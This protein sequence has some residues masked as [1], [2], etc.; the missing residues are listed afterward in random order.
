M[1][2]VENIFRENDFLENIFRQ[3]PIYVEVNGA[4]TED[5]CFVVV[6]RKIFSNSRIKIGL[7][8]SNRRMRPGRDRVRGVPS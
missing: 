4:S 3:K 5:R 6:H 2:S 7:H 1:F 8:T